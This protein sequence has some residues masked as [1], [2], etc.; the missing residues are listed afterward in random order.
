MSNKEMQDLTIFL[1]E[2]TAFIGKKLKNGQPSS[3]RRVLDEQECMSFVT[4]FIKKYCQECGSNE[5]TLSVNDVP[6]F[7]CGIIEQ[8]KQVEG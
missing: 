3:V 4:W 5:F 7:K 1:G 2:K 6:A 8:E